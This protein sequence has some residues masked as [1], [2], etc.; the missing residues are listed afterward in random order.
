[1]EYTWTVTALATQT[2]GLE[3]NYVMIAT[4]NVVGTDSG[5]TSV[6][7]GTQ[8]FSVTD[9][10]FIPYKDLTN[11]IVI[12]WIKKLVNVVEITSFI[13]AEI[14]VQKNPPAQPENTP[15]PWN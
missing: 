1:M 11:D 14:E 6:V 7:N 5:F 15:L 4:F 2:I 8:K 3:E 9:D 12:S 10:T 13:N